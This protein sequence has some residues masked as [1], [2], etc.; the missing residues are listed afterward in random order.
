MSGTS[1]R[2]M[3]PQYKT[4]KAWLTDLAKSGKTPREMRQITGCHKSYAFKIHKDV[5]LE[6]GKIKPMES[7]VEVEE[8]TKEGIAIPPTPPTEITKP[9]VL[10][11][12]V[13]GKLTPDQ[14]TAIFR[15]VNDLFPEK[16]R[17]PDAD[18]ELLGTLW[19]NPLNR[20]ISKVAEGNEDLIIAVV[21]SIIIYS[22]SVIG[23]IQEHRE[24]QARAKKKR[25][26][27]VD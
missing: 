3:P 21:G 5:G 10:P 12:V 27:E 15:A 11:E 24:E 25:K 14:C 26:M 16:H 18:M 22:P 19:Q 8:I 9:L 7:I 1:K 6:A 23:V 17:R 13:E 20:Y 4:L 2:E